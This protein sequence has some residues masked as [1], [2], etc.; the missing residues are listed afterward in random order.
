MHDGFR[1][2]SDRTCSCC[3]A[4]LPDSRAVLCGRC[5]HAARLDPAYQSRGQVL[6]RGSTGSSSPAGELRR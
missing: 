6:A 4:P 3:P 5:L 2:R 1:K